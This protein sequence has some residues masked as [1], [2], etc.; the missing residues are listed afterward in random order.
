[1]YTTDLTCEEAKFLDKDDDEKCLNV[2]NGVPVVLLLTDSERVYIVMHPDSCGN[3][4]DNE[5]NEVLKG[6]KEF[7]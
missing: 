2:D 7:S 3:S 6:E 5:D 1:V 4:D